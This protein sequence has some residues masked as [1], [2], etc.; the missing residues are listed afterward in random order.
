MNPSFARRLP[1]ALALTVAAMLVVQGCAAPAAVPAQTQPA[2][3]QIALPYAP[4]LRAAGVSSVTVYDN[5]ARVRLATQ[6]GEVYFR[7]PPGVPPAAFIVYVDAQGL[8]VD[9]DTFTPATSP[10]FETALKAVLPLS[11]ERASA[12]NTQQLQEGLG[13]RGGGRGR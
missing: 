2:L 7:Y 13:G 3:T 12:N 11:I 5:G 9:S 6:M 4:Q 10:Q 8:E 1:G